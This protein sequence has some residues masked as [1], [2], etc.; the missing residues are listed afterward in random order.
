MKG[1]AHVLVHVRHMESIT[2]KT[3]F[4][5]L[6]HALQECHLTPKLLLLTDFFPGRL[7]VFSYKA[8]VA[9]VFHLFPYFF[10]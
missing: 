7:C 6:F 9:P 2:K 3:Y 5:I 4:K 8:T 10:I 1:R